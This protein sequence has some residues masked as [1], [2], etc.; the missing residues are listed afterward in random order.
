MQQEQEELLLQEKQMQEELAKMRS[1]R[2][3]ERMN[4]A[5]ARITVM[6]EIRDSL[7]SSYEVLLRACGKTRQDVPE[8][9]QFDAR[10]DIIDKELT[11]CTALYRKLVR[12]LEGGTT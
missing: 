11:A 8:T 6:Q 4:K 3:E 10:L 1:E 2:I 5:R 9:G 7:E 12:S